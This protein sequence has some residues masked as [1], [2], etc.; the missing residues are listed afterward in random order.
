MGNRVVVYA[1]PNGEVRVVNPDARAIEALRAKASRL[2][3]PLTDEQAA[4]LIC[5]DA[6]PTDAG[7]PAVVDPANLPDRRWQ[8]AWRLSGGSIVIDMPAARALFLARLRAARESVWPALEAL[9]R[10]HDS[11]IAAAGENKERRA[12]AEQAKA[13]H[14]ADKQAWRDMPETLGVEKAQT[15]DQLVALWPRPLPPL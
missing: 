7:A 3:Q 1:A 10:K 6:V 9:D 15:L 4:A 8:E 14:E 11:A 2:A 13:A 5:A 12:A